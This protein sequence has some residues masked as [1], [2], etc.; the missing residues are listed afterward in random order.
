MKITLFVASWIWT[1]SLSWKQI[2]SIFHSHFPKISHFFLNFLL[3]SANLQNINKIM[4]FLN[5]TYMLPI[6]L[7]WNQIHSIFHSHF[8]K[9]SHF[10]LFFFQKSIKKCLIHV[11]DWC[12]SYIMLTEYLIY[13]LISRYFI[14]T[15]VLCIFFNDLYKSV[16][17]AGVS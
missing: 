13:C 12:Y 1:A 16:F 2:H 15:S 11:L 10:L 3:K 4:I 8:P 6:K 14:K 17:F 5:E 7:S 9:I